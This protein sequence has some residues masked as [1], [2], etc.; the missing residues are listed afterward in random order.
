MM[1]YYATPGEFDE[2]IAR[3]NAMVDDRRGGGE[4]PRNSRRADDDGSPRF[5]A[6]Y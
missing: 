3:E 4:G 1:M 5:R 6:K 2:F